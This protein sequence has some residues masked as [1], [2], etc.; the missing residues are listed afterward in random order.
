M[1]RRCQTLILQPYA[2]TRYAMKSDY[3]VAARKLSVNL[4]LNEDLREVRRGRPS[5]G[6]VRSLRH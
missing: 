4:T 3:D 1:V 2:H 5:G 6:A